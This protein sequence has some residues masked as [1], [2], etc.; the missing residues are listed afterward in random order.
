MPNKQTELKA[1]TLLH[2]S[3]FLW[4]FTAILGKL[5]SYDSFQLVWHRMSITAFVYFLFPS[6]WKNLKQ[7]SLKQIF[8]FVGIGALVCAHWLTFYG[9]IK[10]GNS[11]SLTLACLGCASLFTAIIEPLLL[12]KK[13]NTPDLLAGIVVLLGVGLITASLPVNSSPTV[14]YTWSIISGLISALLAALFS[15]LNKKNI[16]LTS[17]ITISAIEMLS[18]ATILTL[19]TPLLYSKS[20][21][22]IP[23]FNIDNFDPN[24]LQ[25]GSLDLLWLIILSLVCTNLTFYLAT[26]ALSSIS[27]FSS[28]LAVNLE[29]VYGIILGALIFQENKQ[30]NSTFYFGAGIILLSIFTNAL[31]TKKNNGNS[32]TPKKS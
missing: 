22:N 12:G 15:T 8:T 20:Q 18:G 21:L 14:S 29:P 30:L 32:R 23:Q 26:K 24:Q 3:V 9:S 1:F 7:L 4:G 2:I 17:P 27:A 19:L 10:Y 16:H 13:I 25:N 11:V 28:N 6:V 5:I 31:L